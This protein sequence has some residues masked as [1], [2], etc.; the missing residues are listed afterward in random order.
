MWHHW[1][2][3]FEGTLEFFDSDVEG[4][5]RENLEEWVQRLLKPDRWEDGEVKD[6]PDHTW[7]TKGEA[8]FSLQFTEQK[9][10]FYETQEL[11]A[12]HAA[13]KRYLRTLYQTNADE[14]SERNLI[15][16]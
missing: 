11:V 2:D 3:L 15:T 13:G 12:Q 10:H 1:E 9:R 4:K 6:Q 7:T 16:K 5:L 14:A 8:E